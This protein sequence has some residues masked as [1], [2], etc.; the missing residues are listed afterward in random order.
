M[1]PE[2]ERIS[3]A[4]HRAR[5]RLQPRTDRCTLPGEEPALVA[6]LTA[7]VRAQTRSADWFDALPPIEQLVAEHNDRRR[8]E[9]LE[10]ERYAR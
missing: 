10:V 2:L 6:E 9:R 7:L 5:A 1:S 4:H 8:L 3:A